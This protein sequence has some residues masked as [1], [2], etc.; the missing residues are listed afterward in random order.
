MRWLSALWLSGPIVFKDFL[1]GVS[2]IAVSLVAVIAGCAF[3]SAGNM[4]W[5]GFLGLA[6]AMSLHGCIPQIR[7][8]KAVLTNQPSLR[9]DDD[10]LPLAA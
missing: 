9:D 8:M 3:A 5:F 1:G 10:T 2:G 6:G 7:L 4:A